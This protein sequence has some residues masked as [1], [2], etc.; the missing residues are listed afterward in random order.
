VLFRIDPRPFQA[1]LDQ[2]LAKL[3]SDQAQ[4]QNAQRDA[5]RYRT[6]VQKDYVTKSQ[7]DQAEAAAAA[8]AATVKADQA[9][10]ENARLNLAY[11]TVRAPIAGRTGSV[12]VRKGNVAQTGNA[13]PLVV[14][15]QIHPILVRFSIPQS[16]LPTLQQYAAHG[17][18]P[19]R[20]KPAEGNG[21]TVTGTL[22]FIDNSVDSA[23]GT[24]VLK[25]TFPNADN[26]LWPGQFVAVTLQLFMQH[27]AVTV[28]SQAVLTGQQGTYVFTVNKD[29]TTKQ[30]PV[31]VNRTL[32]TTVVIERGL[33]PGETV[34]IDGQSRL[35]PGAKVE[36]KKGAV[37]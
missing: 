31:V 34:I 23:T 25:A 18:L 11:T 3:A 20:V 15:N 24:V 1:A 37:S 10:V 2:A 13:T 12:L 21:S 4:A 28:P 26:T 33:S 9:A 19:V 22:S 14:I 5:E 30:Q 35:S 27:D 32:D 7:A 36:I 16:Q 17:Q 29:G 8:Q 6:L